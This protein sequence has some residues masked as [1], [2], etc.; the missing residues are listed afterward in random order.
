MSQ[1]RHIS[2]KENPADLA[3][4]PMPANHLIGNTLWLKGPLWWCM[5][6]DE[7]TK[8]PDNVEIPLERPTEIIISLTATTT[9][10][11]KKSGPQATIAQ[12]DKSQPIRDKL[13]LEGETWMECLELSEK[14]IPELYPQLNQLLQL[15]GSRPEILALPI[16]QE[17]QQKC[18]KELWHGLTT[19]HLPHHLRDMVM[20]NG[21]Q[22]ITLHEMQIIVSNR[23]PPSCH[24]TSS[25]SER[26]INNVQ[27]AAIAKTILRNSLI[28]RTK[29]NSSNICCINTS[30]SSSRHLPLLPCASWNMSTKVQLMGLKMQ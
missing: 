27:R 21:L 20:K 22:L 30:S 16:I 29:Q 6:K 28:K 5:P 10:E 26:F 1:W 24:F 11:P 12:T 15:N 8:Q 25:D 13:L 14:A 2:G 9:S 3:T 4:K 23:P 18:A 7:W 17:V 19:N